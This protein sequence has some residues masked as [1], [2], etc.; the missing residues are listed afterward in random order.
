LPSPRL[1][2]QNESINGIY[3][4]GACK[5]PKRVYYLIKHICAKVNGPTVGA[6]IY[7]HYLIAIINQR[8]WVCAIGHYSAQQLQSPV[9]CDEVDIA[10]NYTIPIPIRGPIDLA[11]W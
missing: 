8:A 1:I 6:A 11:H 5:G 9:A 7:Q 2:P 4:V 10:A 3:P